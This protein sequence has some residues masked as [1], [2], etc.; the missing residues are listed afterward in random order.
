VPLLPPLKLLM[1]LVWLLL[2][3]EYEAPNAPLLLPE[4]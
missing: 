3:P 4:V 2:G 1:L